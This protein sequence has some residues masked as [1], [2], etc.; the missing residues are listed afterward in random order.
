MR[1]RKRSRFA[2]SIRL[3]WAVLSSA[4]APKR[5]RSGRRSDSGSM[6][7]RHGRREAEG[8]AGGAGTVR[9][10]RALV[11]VTRSRCVIDLPDI[12]PVRP[13]RSLWGAFL[14]AT[15]TGLTALGLGVAVDPAAD[16]RSGAGS[17]PGRG[18]TVEPRR[19]RAV[20]GREPIVAVARGLASGRPGS[21]Q[22]LVSGAARPDI[23]RVDVTAR[24]RGTS[25]RG[26]LR[27]ARGRNPDGRYADRALVGDPRRAARAGPTGRRRD[28]HAARWITTHGDAG[29]SA[30]V[31]ALGDG[32]G[33]RLSGQPTA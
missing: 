31:V 15:L 30:L 18:I 5:E 4:D 19:R 12:A 14:L 22:L 1:A 17:G 25:R 16:H 23:V 27:P 33:H 9:R 10:Q 8:R 20:S 7:R 3:E 21:T 29:T 2:R 26:R 32:R 28:G 13:R 11:A 6:N 24:G